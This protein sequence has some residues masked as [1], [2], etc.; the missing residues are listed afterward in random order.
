MEEER[1]KVRMLEEE[2]G[3]ERGKRR[4][5]EAELE[6]ERKAVGEL[7]EALHRKM[8][9]LDGMMLAKGWVKKGEP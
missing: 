2:L 9:R 3:E 6:A 8:G 4:K 5:V 1:R 7:K